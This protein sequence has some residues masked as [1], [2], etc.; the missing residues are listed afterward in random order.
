MSE[1]HNA[2]AAPEGPSFG[3]GDSAAGW[4]VLVPVE[5]LEGETVTESVVEL[6]GGLPV[7]VLGYHVLPEQT[8]PGQARLQYEAQAQTKLDDLAA[9]FRAAGGGVETRL[10]FT[11]DE[12]QTINRVADEAGCEAILL[13][14]PTSPVERVLV[15]LRGEADARRI[16]GFV[17]AL[18]GGR[19]IEVTL[20]HVAEADT[21]GASGQSLLDTATAVLREGGLPEDAVTQRVEVTDTPVQRIAEVATEYDTVVMG[22]SEPSLGR[23]VF[24]DPSERVATESLGPVIVVR[25]A[26][27]ASE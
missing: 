8:P 22:E 17:T 26:E 27:S 7:V 10:V 2:G 1:D 16:A 18:V 24:G 20:L 5:V 11:H 3:A 6:L 13:P 4:R 14:N 9:T 19:D 21:Q 25:R 15:P 23:F 12:E